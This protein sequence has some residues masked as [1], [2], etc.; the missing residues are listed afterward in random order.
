MAEEEHTFETAGA[1]ASL[2]FPMQCSALRKNG[3]VV[4]KG[5]PCKIVD[6]STSKTGKHGHAKVHLV[7]IDIFTNKKLEDLSPSTHNMEVPVVKRT[8][9][10][11]LDIDDGFLSLMN[12]DG[13][14][15]DDVRAPEGELGDN[16]QAAF[17]EG[18]DLMVTIISAMGEEAAISFKEAPRSD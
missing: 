10:Q 5:R 14:T 3:F 18:K 7:A 4:I 15:K 9:Y 6:M 16:M 12:M 8:E 2:T 1:G 17:D 11:L 13:D